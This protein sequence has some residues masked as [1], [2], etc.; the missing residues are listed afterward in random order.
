MVSSAI[1]CASMSVSV[2]RAEVGAM[3]GGAEHDS[4]IPYVLGAILD[5]PDPYSSYWVQQHIGLGPHSVLNPDGEANGDGRP[6]V[7]LH[8]TTRTPLVVWSRNSPGGFD[9]VLS[10]FE[11]GAWTDAVVLADLVEDALDPR[12]AIDA[13]TGVVHLVYWVD[14]VEPRVEYRSAPGDLSV[15]SSPQTVSDVGEAAC[16]PQAVVHDGVLRVAYEVHVPGAGGTP[17]QIV[18]SRLEPGGFVQEIVAQTGHDGVVRPEVH[19]HAGRIW[20]DWVDDDDVVA[21]TRFD[22]VADVWTPIRTELFSG[23][24]EREFH[25]RGAVRAKAIE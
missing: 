6:D 25:V 14:D 21:W 15:W 13:A 24:E 22:P 17:R 12:L 1:M 10:T 3:L 16:R 18:L 19:S 4:P 8:P 20:V 7:A 5:E 23:I 11:G 2:G 9:V